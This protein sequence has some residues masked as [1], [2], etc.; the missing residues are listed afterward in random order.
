MP[1]G[2]KKEK[3]EQA[4]APTISLEEQILVNGKQIIEAEKELTNL[5]EQREML[6]SLKEK[7]DFNE[8]YTI[9][10]KSGVSVGELLNKMVGQS[11]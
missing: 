8:L 2:V 5:K 7:A 6:L 11:D 1:R 4:I 9:I 3:T 10:K